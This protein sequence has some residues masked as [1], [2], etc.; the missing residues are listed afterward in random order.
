MRARF[1][2]LAIL[3]AGCAYPT[4]VE[5]PA[6]AGAPASRLPEVTGPFERKRP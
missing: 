2:A 1:L 6:A 3:L 5:V 4:P